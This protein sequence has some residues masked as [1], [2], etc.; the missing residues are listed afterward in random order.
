MGLGYRITYRGWQFWKAIIA[1]PL[2]KS[3]EEEVA[4]VLSEEQMVLFLRQ[5]LAGQQH[6]YRVMRLLMDNGHQ[7][8]E[9]LVAALLHDCGK[10]RVTASWWDRSVAVLA[11]AAFPNRV[12]QWAKADPTGWRRPFVIKASH[13]G[14]GAVYAEAVGCT[15]LTVNL[16]RRHQDPV[17]AKTADR[18]GELLILLQWADDQS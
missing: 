14:W 13:A 4:N 6:A 5:P 1:R 2:S 11:Q 12:Q 7:D 16:V 9:L 15:D 18:E 8:Q 17:V 3:L 10:I